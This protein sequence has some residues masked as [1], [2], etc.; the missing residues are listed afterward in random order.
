M[1]IAITGSTG[2]IGE[3][4]IRELAGA[5]HQVVRMVRSAPSGTDILWRPGGTLDPAA[6]RGIDAVI[7]LAGESIGGSSP[8]D[9]R[10]TRAKKARILGS[11]VE[12]TTTIAEAVARSDGGPRVMVSASAIGLYGNRGEEVLTED[13]APGQDFLAEVV[14][15]WEAAAE[16]ARTAGVRVVHPR[17]GIVLDPDG[18]ALQKMLPLFRAGVGGK[19]GDGSQ[20]WSWVSVADVVGAIRWMVETG[21]AEGP[22]NVTGPHPTTNA[23]FTAV[24]G[25]VLG[26]PTFVTVPAFGPKLLLG[27]L[28]D[29]LLF[30]SQRVDSS[31]LAAAGYAFRFA[32]LA[33]ALR[34]VLGT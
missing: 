33:P 2:L 6:L 20:W 23:E 18:G 14:T 26:R 11:R 32:D 5:G 34:D 28:A 22:Y 13:R 17:I 4:L 27:E 3:Q 16:P 1:K 19:F 15:A 24:L 30:N 25:E 29:A 21:S 12:G 9:L 10:W 7:H 8:L 31:K